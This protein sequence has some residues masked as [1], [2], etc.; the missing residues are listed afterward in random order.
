MLSARIFYSNC[1]VIHDVSFC[2]SIHNISLYQSN[3]EMLL[4]LLGRVYHPW[5][6]LRCVT[7]NIGGSK[8]W[9]PFPY[10]HHHSLDVHDED[11]SLAEVNFA[12]LYTPPD[13]CFDK[14]CV[15]TRKTICVCLILLY[16]AI[17]SSFDGHFIF[18]FSFFLS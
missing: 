6:G 1:A 18:V 14:S 17:G 4:N 13:L 15:M 16:K 8:T 5:D 12:L 11:V 7:Y 2:I 3:K 10:L 9:L